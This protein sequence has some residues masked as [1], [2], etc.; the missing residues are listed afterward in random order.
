MKV[1]FEFEGEFPIRLCESS[2]G[3]FVLTY[4]EDFRRGMTRSEAATALGFAI[5][6]SCQCAGVLDPEPEEEDDSWS[7]DDGLS[8]VEADSMTLASAG[9]GTDEDY[10]YFGEDD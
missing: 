2:P 7:D 8:D 5:L 1:V 3:E 6:H 4:G 9:W 10:G